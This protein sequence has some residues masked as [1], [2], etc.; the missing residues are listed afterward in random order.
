MKSAVKTLSVIFSAFFILISIVTI[1]AVEDLRLETWTKNLFN[2]N[3]LIRKSSAKNLGFL[4]DRR[5]IP[6]LI[7]ALKDS[8]NE[9]RA[10]ACNALGLLG[11]ESAKEPLQNVLSR[12]SSQTVRYSAKKAID[13]IDSYLNLQK[14]KK[15]KE[16]KE[17]LKN[18][19]TPKNM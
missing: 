8:E 18:E 11:D 17:R 13:N 16:L 1:D 6:S 14:E 9:V 5:A 19:S 2:E 3:S 10:E 12:D 15:L 4:G 7:K